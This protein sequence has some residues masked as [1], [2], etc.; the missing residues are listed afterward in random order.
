MPCAT[1]GGPLTGRAKRYCSDF[2]AKAKPCRTCGTLKVGQSP[3]CPDCRRDRTPSVELCLDPEWLARQATRDERPKRKPQGGPTDL[4]W[5]AGCRDW[6]SPRWFLSWKQ[7]KAQAKVPD[8][9]RPCRSARGHAAKIKA[10][11]GMTPED[12]DALLALQ[13]GGCA[14]CDGKP[15]TERL[16]VDHDHETGAVRGLLCSKDN[17]ELL[18]GVRHSHRLASRAALYLISPPA[19]T[20]VAVPYA[21][22]I[23][24]EELRLLVQ[25]AACALLGDAALEV[26]CDDVP[27]LRDL[28]DRLW[29]ELDPTAG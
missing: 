11:Y 8:R 6:L 23:A 19:Q 3:Y 26:C 16:S 27:R 5:C 7:I 18:S 1:C 25:G 15:K 9:C 17:S 12:Y 14:I 4:W 22:S 10:E 28:V 20:G 21:T 2:C 24:T 13:G 29:V